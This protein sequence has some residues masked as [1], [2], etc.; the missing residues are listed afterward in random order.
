MSGKR[1]KRIKK[2]SFQDNY[3]KPLYSRKIIRLFWKKS[4]FRKDKRKS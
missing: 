2:L 4:A 1:T 3:V